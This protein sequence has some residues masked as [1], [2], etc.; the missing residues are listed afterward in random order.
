MPKG[1][2]VQVP[3]CAQV[4]YYVEMSAVEQPNSLNNEESS[5]RREAWRLAFSSSRE[6]FESTIQEAGLDAGEIQALRNGRDHLHPDSIH[7]KIAHSGSFPSRILF[8]MH[9]KEQGKEMK[10]I[11]PLERRTATY[12]GIQHAQERAPGLRK[13]ENLLRKRKEIG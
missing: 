13:I 10:E 12:A 5:V 8:G 3:P 9:D 4:C 1:L 2:G 6:E 11:S 7:H